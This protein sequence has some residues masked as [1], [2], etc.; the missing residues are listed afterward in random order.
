M[1]VLEN[2][3][4]NKF[5][6]ALEIVEKLEKI[7]PVKGNQPR[8]VVDLIQAVEKALTDLSALGSTGAMKN[9]LIVKSI[10]SKL[11]E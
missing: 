10:E 8:K 11:P 6:I 3:Y 5:T 9:P 1:F 4:G 2:R 7:P